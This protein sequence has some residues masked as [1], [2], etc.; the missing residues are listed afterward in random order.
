MSHT[1]DDE[2][3]EVV[4]VRHGSRD[5]PI[6]I[7]DDEVEYLGYSVPGELRPGMYHRRLPTGEWLTVV[8]V[9]V[10]RRLRCH[11]PDTA[12]TGSGRIAAKTVLWTRRPRSVVLATEAQT[13]IA[14]AHRPKAH[15][16]H[17]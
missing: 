11:A 3:G 12:D 6:E 10:R 14:R 9:Q 15:H 16:C 5:W 7:V 17:A 8:V 1:G 4:Y 2:H 13:A